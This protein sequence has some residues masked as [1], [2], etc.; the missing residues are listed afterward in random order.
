MSETKYFDLHTTG[1]GYLNRARVV[2]VKRG[3][4][5][6][7]VNV[8]A[9]H[10]AADS[11][12]YTRFDCRVCGEAAAHVLLDLKGLIEAK[13][14]DGRPAHR[15]LA[16]FKLSDL[17]AETSHGSWSRTRRKSAAARSRCTTSAWLAPCRL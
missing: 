10:G 1:I 14:P 16:G 4:P 12:E 13:G 11:P 2:D 6:L 17:Y 8:N 15:V 7:A 5:F 9:L 3:T